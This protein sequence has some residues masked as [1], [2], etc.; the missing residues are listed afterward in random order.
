MYKDERGIV[1]K[2]SNE[3]GSVGK[4]AI[5]SNRL[6]WVRR[7]ASDWIWP[8]ALVCACPSGRVPRA[9]L[10]ALGPDCASMGT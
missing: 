7:L 1:S 3:G 8:G 4:L 6:D 10:G 9:C 2:V 5:S